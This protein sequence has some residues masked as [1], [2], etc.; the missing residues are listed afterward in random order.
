MLEIN[1][2]YKEPK[3]I[4]E[5]LFKDK[6]SK[7]FGY[8]YPVK[9]KEDIDRSL[10]EIRKQHHAARHVCYAWTLGSE[11]IESK[12]TDDGEPHNSA[13]P[14]IM[15][16]INS[17]ELHNTLIAVVR[18]FGGTKLG[19]GGLINAYKTA[20][21]EAILNGDIETHYLQRNFRLQFPYEIMSDVM[22]M[23]KQDGVNITRQDFTESC[24]LEVT[25]RLK[26][27]DQ[28]LDQLNKLHLLKIKAL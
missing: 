10:K 6:G 20:A 25:I 23:A 7:H 14:P 24:I 11:T 16:Q 27:T 4:S 1:D 19:V 18:Y 26:Y 22:R 2:E 12:F 28:I 8:V 9:S 5:S 21:K 17:F 3:G 13:G 15:G